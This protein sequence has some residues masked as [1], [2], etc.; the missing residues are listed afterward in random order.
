MI[1]GFSACALAH[2]NFDPTVLRT[3]LCGG[4][5]P[6]WRKLTEGEG[7]DVVGVLQLD[8]TNYMGSKDFDVVLISDFT[9]RDQNKF[10]GKLLDEYLPTLKWGYD[11]CGYAVMLALIMLRG[12]NK[13]K[14]LPFF[15]HYNPLLII[16]RIFSLRLSFN[17]GK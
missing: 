17:T 4:V 16:N 7:A 15:Y 9:N 11:K 12:T 10:L 2:P 13:V 14:K 8:M 5:A 1:P 3:A 6:D